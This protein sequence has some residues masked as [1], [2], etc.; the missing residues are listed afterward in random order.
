MLN[1]FPPLFI[2]LLDY[3]RILKNYNIFTIKIV[4]ILVKKLGG[5]RTG[6]FSWNAIVE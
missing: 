3:I 2:V 5:W 6:L 4:L 1:V